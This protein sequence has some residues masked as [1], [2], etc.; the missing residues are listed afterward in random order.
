MEGGREGACA[1]NYVVLE[2]ILRTS[3]VLLPRTALLSPPYQR[4][5]EVG[6]LLRLNDA[7]C[8]SL[9]FTPTKARETPTPHG[10]LPQTLVGPLPPFPRTH[11]IHH[12]V[13]IVLYEVL[14]VS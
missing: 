7:L 3:A 12:D 6:S 8:S 10:L 11:E 1:R 4:W 9:A 2:E 14:E 5:G 13:V